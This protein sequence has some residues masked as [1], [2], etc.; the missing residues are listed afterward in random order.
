[1]RQCLNYEKT[2]HHRQG[3]SRNQTLSVAVVLDNY[4]SA[5]SDRVVS[6]YRFTGWEKS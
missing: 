6:L 5:I 4:N 1:M 2:L 3:Y